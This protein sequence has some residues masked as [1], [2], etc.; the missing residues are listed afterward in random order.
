MANHQEKYDYYE[1]Y[2]HNEHQQITYGVHKEHALQKVVINKILKSSY[3]LPVDVS[4]FINCFSHLVMLEEDPL[5]WFIITR[6]LDGMPLFSE[7]NPKEDQGELSIKKDQMLQFLSQIA[8][9]DFLAPFY[10]FYLLKESNWII[11]DGAVLSKELLIF[12]Q[13]HEGFIDFSL[14]RAQSNALILKLISRSDLA[15][16]ELLSLDKITEETQYIN[17]LERL[18]DYWQKAISTADALPRP[19]LLQNLYTMPSEAAAAPM[20]KR[21]VIESVKAAND[22]SEVENHRKPFIK[23]AIALTMV[24]A[25][26]CL[27]ILAVPA[28]K[29]LLEPKKE[30]ETI[31]NNSQTNSGET[32]S[33]I[34]D[35]SLTLDQIQLEGNG[36]SIDQ[37]IFYTGTESIQLALTDVN[38]SGKMIITPI[39]LNKNSSISVWLRSSQSGSIRMQVSL[40]HDQEQLSKVEST[41]P[42]EANDTWYLTSLLSSNLPKNIEAVNRLEIEWSGDP[43]ILWFDD[44]I[45]ES[46]K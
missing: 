31:A 11:K 23:P 13:L 15:N 35:K 30:S 36:W 26:I 14:V 16:I 19:V 39:D 37:S 1:I 8:Q 42:I 41:V 9:Y 29:L 12:D 10:Q 27:I 22:L 3:V 40:Y 6:K 7:E 38:K 33:T 5:H 28:I 2:I 20:A 44:L 21:R 4:S 24:T 18:S 34:E 43:Q 32:I 25:L 45:I 17:S 46:Y